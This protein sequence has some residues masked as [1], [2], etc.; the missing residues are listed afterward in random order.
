MAVNTLYFPISGIQGGP[1]EGKT[2]G[3]ETTYEAIVTTQQQDEKTL[4]LGK[5][6]EKEK[7]M[8]V[9]RITLKDLI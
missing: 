8:T 1:G 7:E 2:R 5:S 3:T 9:K 6:H 4:K